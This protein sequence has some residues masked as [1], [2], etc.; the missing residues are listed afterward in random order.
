MKKHSF[1]LFFLFFTLL[2]CVSQ[3]PQDSVKKAENPIPL[4]VELKQGSI[5]KGKLVE[6]RGDT[7]IID[8]DNLV[9]IKVPMN[10]IKNIEEAGKVGENKIFYET[11][12]PNKYANRTI[13][14]PTALDND[15]GVGEYNNYYLFLNHFSA[16]VTSYLRLGSG[17]I[18]VPRDRLTLV[19]FA[20][21]KLSYSISDNFRIS[22]GGVAGTILLNGEKGWAG[23]MYG[24]GTW[25]NK[26]NNLTVGVGSLRIE[27]RWTDAVLM[28]TGQKRLSNNWIVVGEFFTVKDESERVVALTVG[29][30]YM[31]HKL[32]INFGIMTAGDFN[33]GITEIIPIPIIGLSI[34]LDKKQIK[35][36]K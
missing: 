20:S 19:G 31:L 17:V 21:I 23:A 2:K 28:L 6:R 12:V 1:T 30:K 3:N 26:D 13:L 22:T 8:A 29:A 18:I 15:K 10:Q 34:P 7:L 16:G 11:R 32:S 24:L 33:S 27:S 9:L 25:G 14:T 36:V 35:K 4:V 5:L